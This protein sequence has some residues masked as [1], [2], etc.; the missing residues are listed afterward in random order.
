MSTETDQGL[1]RRPAWAIGVALVCLFLLVPAPGAGA[2]STRAQAGK[3]GGSTRSDLRDAQARLKELAGRI[4]RGEAAAAA[5]RSRI[6]PLSSKLGV[7]QAA[8]DDAERRLVVVRR[9][10]AVATSLHAQLQARLGARAQEALTLGSGSQIDMLLGSSSFAELGDRLAFLNQLQAADQELAAQVAATERTLHARQ[11]DLEHGLSQT[12]TLL[13]G[14]QAQQARFL[15]MLSQQQAQ[16]RRIA[17]AREQATALVERLHARLKAQVSAQLLSRLQSGSTAP[18]G[19]WAKLFL[20]HIKAPTCRD[21]LVVLVAW[22]ASEGTSASWNPLA[23]TYPMPGATALNGVGVRNYVSL[24]Q[25]LAATQ[26]TLGNGATGYGAILA[27]LHSCAAAID[28]AR[29]INASAWCSG[30]AG[31]Q[32]VVGIVPTVEAFFDQYQAMQN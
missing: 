21:N 20:Q 22:Q 15:S 28:T 8:Y 13:T 5:M 26:L 2:A 23:T 16:L 14:L 30:C 10:I 3:A 18:Y 7:E 17:K 19:T 9:Q 31:G 29:A 25:G 27:G 6:K 24:D 11:A 32:Y 12:T 4:S 1:G